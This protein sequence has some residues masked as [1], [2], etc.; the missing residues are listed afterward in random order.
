MHA[1]RFENT[2]VSSGEEGLVLI[3][4]LEKVHII[5]LSICLFILYCIQ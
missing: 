3:W 4:D 1:E 5:Y 2:V